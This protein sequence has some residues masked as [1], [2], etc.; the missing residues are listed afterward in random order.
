MGV[1]M[2]TILLSQARHNLA[3]NIPVSFSQVKHDF[4]NS[5]PTSRQSKD[6]SRGLTAFPE[7]F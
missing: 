1:E 2:K 5:D 4:L 3:L 6:F 7:K